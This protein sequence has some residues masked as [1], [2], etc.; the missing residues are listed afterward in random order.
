MKDKNKNYSNVVRKH[1]LEILN[2]EPDDAGLN[3]FMNLL[4]NNIV[5]EKELERIFKNSLEYKLSHPLEID[6]RNLT[7]EEIM[8]KEWNERSKID[9]KFAIRTC[10][11]QTDK[12]FWDSGIKARDLILSVNSSRFNLILQEKDPKNM[13]VLEIGCGIGRILIPMASIF[14]EAIGID[15]SKEMVKTGNEYIKNIPNCRILENNGSDLNMFP[16]D[17]FDFCYSVLVFQ[18]MPKKEIIK[19]YVQ[20]IARVL[21]KNGIF[22]FQV[23]GTV[24]TKQHEITTWNGVRL[25]SQEIHEM[26]ENNQFE[27]LEENGENTDYYWL[28]FRSVK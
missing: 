8:K 25:S 9:T 18:H 17:S 10:L 3:Y 6:K 15:V 19:K 13:K 4:E 26:A 12:E 20:E 28:T 2:R 23:R 22:W 5:N 27:I 1:Y 24:P 7:P 14:G 16:N 11:N 21:K